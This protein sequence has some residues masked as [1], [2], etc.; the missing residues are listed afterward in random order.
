MDASRQKNSETSQFSPHSW[1]SQVTYRLHGSIVFNVSRD[2]LLHL[3]T[4]YR[5]THA[6]LFSPRPPMWP[7]SGP[8]ECVV[9]IL[10]K[11]NA[12][13]VIPL[14]V[15]STVLSW[16]DLGGWGKLGELGRVERLGR[17][18]KVWESW[19]SWGRAGRAGT[20]GRAWESLGMF[21]ELRGIGSASSPKVLP[22]S[23]PSSPKL[24]LLFQLSHTWPYLLF[25]FRLPNT[26][27]HLK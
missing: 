22:S 8:K 7:Q 17:T 27:M 16:R 4:P 23:P 19:E 26:S 2:S 15:V 6:I 18:G 14:P 3:R 24:S 1:W 20:A 10:S 21:G 9:I 25:S 5:K 11:W 12:I 13:C